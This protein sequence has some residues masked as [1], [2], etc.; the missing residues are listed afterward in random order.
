MEDLEN[1]VNKRVVLTTK[2]EVCC[3]MLNIKNLTKTYDNEY[4]AVENISFS[5]K[6][7][8]IVSLLGHNGAGKST[9]LKIIASILAPTKGNIEIDNISL[10]NINPNQLRRIKRNIGFLPENPFLIDQLTPDEYLFYIGKLY[11]IEDD[12]KLCDSINYL[13]SLFDIDN[14]KSKFINEY[15]SGL[16]KRISI[17]SVLINKPGLLLLD[18]PTNNLDPIGVKV[19]KEYLRKLKEEGT[20]VLLATHRL[21]FSETISDQIIIIEKGKSEFQGTLNDLNEKCGTSGK[22]NSLEEL[23]SSL[24]KH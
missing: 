1:Y 21:E 8:Q 24:L 17:A 13:I 7:G 18:E 9:I 16:K 14:S 22:S 6:K 5:V 4:Y 10:F 20:A 11:G 2:N 15:S 3:A 23:Y 19:L 12:N